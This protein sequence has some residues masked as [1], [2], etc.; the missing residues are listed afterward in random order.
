[1]KQQHV[2]SGILGAASPTGA[3]AQA[4]PSKPIRQVIPFMPGGGTDV[5]SRI[6]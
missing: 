6:E 5:V 4:Y 2:L 3:A 1:M